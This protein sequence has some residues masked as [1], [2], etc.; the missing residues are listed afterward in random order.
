[1]S[2]AYAK[3]WDCNGTTG[4]GKERTSLKEHINHGADNER[5]TTKDMRGFSTNNPDKGIE[6]ML[7]NGKMKGCD[8]CIYQAVLSLERGVKLSDEQL[9]IALS[10]IDKKMGPQWARLQRIVVEHVKDGKQHFHIL[11]GKVDPKD[12]KIVNTWKGGNRLD[13]ATRII[14]RKLGLR[15]GTSRKFRHHESHHRNFSYNTVKQAERLSLDLK[16]VRRKVDKAQWDSFTKRGWNSRNSMKRFQKELRRNGLLMARSKFKKGIC[17]VDAKTGANLGGVSKYLA[18]PFREIYSKDLRANPNFA[19]SLPS[20]S[21]VKSN[22]RSRSL[23]ATPRPKT[24]AKAPAAKQDFGAKAIGKG[25]GGLLKSVPMVGAIMA[26]AAKDQ[27]AGAKEEAHNAR[28]EAETARAVRQS[29]RRGEKAQEQ[30]TQTE[31]L[32]LEQWEKK[33]VET[34]SGNEAA[35]RE[36][37]TFKAKG[38]LAEWRERWRHVLG[39]PPP[40]GQRLKRKLGV[41]L[42]GPSGP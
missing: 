23:R 2:G 35:M 10:V 12:G 40:P 29:E 14:E 5:V 31:P 13:K 27:A 6:E 17:L 37:Q 33:A 30:K 34:V 16:D 36:Y 7:A 26:Q 21:R 28:I 8:K 25:N 22:A 19:R 39:L 4:G 11:Y 41:G 9:K 38:M 20:L 15:Q 3:G 42:N 24:R 18:G 1:M 32:T